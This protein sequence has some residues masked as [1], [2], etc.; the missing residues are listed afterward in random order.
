MLDPYSM[1]C[2]IEH[3]LINSHGLKQHKDAHCD[4]GVEVE[5]LWVDQ[6]PAG[7]HHQ[8]VEVLPHTRG[9]PLPLRLDSNHCRC[10]QQAQ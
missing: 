4:N 10:R 6:H 1:Y 5:E 9:G 7:V 2:M 8:Q 3:Y